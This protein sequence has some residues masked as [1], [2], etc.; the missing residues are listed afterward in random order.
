MALYDELAPIQTQLEANGLRLRYGVVPYSST[1]NVGALIRAANPAYLVDTLTYQT[2][3]ARL[4]RPGRR[5]Y[6]RAAEP[7]GT[8]VE[9]TYEQ[10]RSP[11]S[12]CDKYGRNVS[13]GSF[14]PERDHRR[15]PAAGDDL[16]AHLL[17]QRSAG[18]DWGWSGAPDTHAATTARCRRRYVQTD[19]TYAAPSITTNPAAGPTSR[20]SIDVS[21]Y[22][23]GNADQRSRPTRD[24][25]TDRSAAPTTRSSWRPMRHRR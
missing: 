20:E 23:L 22:K 16:D 8:P 4:R 17:E 3:V 15:R 11:Q 14:T 25:Q 12:D 13:F 24:G 19:T 9:Q 21:Q 6:A 1:V 2:R 5:I 18:V 7:R 10:A